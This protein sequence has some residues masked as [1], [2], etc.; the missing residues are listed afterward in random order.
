MGE[1][2]K[3]VADVMMTLFLLGTMVMCVFRPDLMALWFKQADPRFDEN[4]QRL[5]WILRF[6]GVVGLG[7]G[8]VFSIVLIRSFGN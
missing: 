7:I 5:L 3:N 2:L 6:I 8:L 1:D 4:D